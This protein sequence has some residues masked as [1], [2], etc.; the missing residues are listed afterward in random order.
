MIKEAMARRPKSNVSM[1]SGI[2]KTKKNW[3]ILIMIFLYSEN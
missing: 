1:I 2:K 3:F